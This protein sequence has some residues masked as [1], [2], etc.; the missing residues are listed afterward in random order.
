MPLYRKRSSVP[1]VETTT[2]PLSCCLLWQNIHLQVCLPSTGTRNNHIRAK[3]RADVRSV[4]T[5]LGPLPSNLLLNLPSRENSIRE[6]ARVNCKN[7]KKLC[8]GTLMF[9]MASAQTQKSEICQTQIWHYG[10]RL[11][12]FFFLRGGGQARQSEFKKKKKVTTAL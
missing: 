1:S 9:N 10:I 11:F 7:R 2:S 5:S 8:L 12:L 3:R 4:R 6:V